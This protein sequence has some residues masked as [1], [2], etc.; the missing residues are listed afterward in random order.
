MTTQMSFVISQHSKTMKNSEKPLKS[1]P[2]TTYRDPE[3][4]RW[5]VVK[6]QQTTASSEEKAA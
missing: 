3:T 2:F 5:V 1:N 4:G 6:D